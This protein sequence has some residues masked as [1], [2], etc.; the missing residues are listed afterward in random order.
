MKSLQ[1]FCEDVFKFTKNCF[2]LN[3]PRDLYKELLK[4]TVIFL[5]SRLFNGYHF[6]TPKPIKYVQ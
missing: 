4:L 3:Y 2:E 1:D 5:G 6:K